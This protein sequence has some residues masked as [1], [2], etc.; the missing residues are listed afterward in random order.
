MPAWWRYADPFF[1]KLHASDLARVLPTHPWDDDPDL[2]APPPGRS[3]TEPFED[4]LPVPKLPEPSAATAVIATG[5]IAAT[6]TA[7]TTAGTNVA[8]TTN[9]AAS[10]SAIDASGTAAVGGASSL[11]GASMPPPPP[12]APAAFEPP[13]APIV[14]PPSGVSV[15]EDLLDAAT[16]DEVASLARQML[17]F[18]DDRPA[19]LAAAA[20][21]AGK[22]ERAYEDWLV[23]RG[24][25]RRG[26]REDNEVAKGTR[27][28][29]RAVAAAATLDARDARRAS[30]K[31]P[32]IRGGEIRRRD[33]PR[34][35]DPRSAIY[36]PRAR[37]RARD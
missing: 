10:T 12:A 36:S 26:E 34:R 2:R 11:L 31:P 5:P 8:A 28:W 23:G 30:N 20:K 18:D 37:R 33:D 3:H 35:D 4:G 25:G 16:P 7:A 1:R 21:S 24:L 6:T 22:S 32:G 15:G 9:A 14:V 19:A 27:R 29:L 17:A 13:P